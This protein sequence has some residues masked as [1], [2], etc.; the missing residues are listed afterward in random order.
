VNTETDLQFYTVQEVASILKVTKETVRA[1]I[2]EGKLE[3][4]KAGRSWRIRH[5]SLRDLV[6][7][8]YGV[9]DEEEA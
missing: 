6:R 1:W 9:P 2:N 3:A 4:F 5:S 7:E 8:Q